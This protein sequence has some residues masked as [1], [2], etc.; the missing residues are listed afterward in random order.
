M[1]GSSRPRFTRSLLAPRH[2]PAWLGVA[3]LHLIAKLPYPALLWL[4]RRLGALVTRLPSP[5]RQIAKANIALCFPELD[6][7][8]QAQLLDANLRDIGLMLVEFAVGWMGSDRQIARIPLQI[9]G[10]EH[11]ESARAQGK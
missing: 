4:G 11:L 9:E 8:A 7:A 10:L 6:A 3:L 1:P 2:W 5:R